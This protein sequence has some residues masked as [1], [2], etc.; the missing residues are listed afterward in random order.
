MENPEVDNEILKEIEGVEWNLGIIFRGT[1]VDFSKIQKDLRERGLHI[2]YVKKVLKDKLVI[3]VEKT[4]Q[5][6]IKE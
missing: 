5:N 4:T 3:Q 1:L 2:F 6:G